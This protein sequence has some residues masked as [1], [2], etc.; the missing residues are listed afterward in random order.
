MSR[1]NAVKKRV[2]IRNLTA[3]VIYILRTKFQ[4]AEYQ[5]NGALC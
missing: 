4:P 3:V 5:L 1:N 2:G